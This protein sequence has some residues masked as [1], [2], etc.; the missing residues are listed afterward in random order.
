MAELKVTP[1]ALGWGRAPDGRFCINVDVQVPTTDGNTIRVPL[2]GFVLTAEE[3]K[4]LIA[5]LTGLVIMAQP[6]PSRNGRN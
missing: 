4:N 5:S 2:M 3:E 6:L 1:R